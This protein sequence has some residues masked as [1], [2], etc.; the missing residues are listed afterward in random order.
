MCV[1]VFDQIVIYSKIFSYLI[2][3]VKDGARY[4][5]P[6][7]YISKVYQLASDY[8]IVKAYTPSMTPWYIELV[9]YETV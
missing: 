7:T 8:I 6:Y 5:T 4:S 2:V 3:W 1:G 9:F